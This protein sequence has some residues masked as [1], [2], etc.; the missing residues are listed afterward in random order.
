VTEL[1]AAVIVGGA[2]G[3]AL[4]RVLGTAPFLLIVMFVGL[5]W[6]ARRG[7]WVPLAVAGAALGAGALT[8]GSALPF[9][10]AVPV[11][12]VGLGIGQLVEKAR[13]A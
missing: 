10:A 5:I 6:H 3:W 2:I 1:L 9:L 13:G 11:W 12:A 7:G 4:D 8:R